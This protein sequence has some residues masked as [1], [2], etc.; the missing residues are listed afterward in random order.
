MGIDIDGLLAQL[1]LEEKVALC[2]GRSTWI[3]NAVP[4]LGIPAMKLSDGPNAARGDAVSGATAACFPVGVALAATWDT[5][6]IEAVGVAL[7]D[8][9]RSK[10][11]QVLLGPTMNL[12]RHPLGGRNFECYSEDPYLSGAMACAFIRGV[13][14]LH[15]AACAKHFVCND[16]EF[17][18]HSI[19]SE[20]LL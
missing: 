13:Q 12:H 19:S 18:R 4:R 14:S 17:E 11:A 15:V 20:V 16:S 6:L 10:N 9:A 5:D 2:A 3:T 7:G 8:E 1:S